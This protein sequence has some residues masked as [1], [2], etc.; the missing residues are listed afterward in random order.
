M[1]SSA[2]SKS[3][4]AEEK[5]TLQEL[6]DPLRWWA[7]LAVSLATFMTY[8]DLNIINI[9]IPAIQHSLHL[10]ESGL[11]WVV[12]SYLLTL[13]GLLLTGGRL[14]D[15]YGRRLLFIIGLI[16]FTLSSLSAGLAVNGTIL[17]TSRA[18]Q[19]VGAAVVTPPTLA[20]IT[21]T[22][23]DAKER[24]NA[25]GLWTVSAAI[26]LA[27][28]PVA[29]GL[30]SQHIH[31]GWIFLINVPVGVIA[32]AITVRTVRESRASDASRN[33]DVIGLVTSAIALFAVTYALIEGNDAGWSSPRIIAAFAAFA[34]AAVLFPTIENRV[35][36]PMVNLRL[37][38]IRY[39][40]GGLSSQVIWAFGS[41][42]I[43][44]FTAQY[45]QGV[46]GWSP[47]KSGLLFL[48]MAAALAVSAG[49]STTVAGWIGAY[50][51]VA[52]G[53]AMIAIGMVML[54][55]N[56][57]HASFGSLVPSLVVMGV[58]MGIMNAP[59]TNAVMENTPETQTGIA[60]ALLNDARD[61]AGLLG[62]AVVGA[63]LRTSQNSALRS[64]S[65]A[66]QAFVDGYHAGILVAAILCAVGVAISY[67]LL[68][69]G[70]NAAPN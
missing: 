50:R 31:W 62:I 36:N 52:L 61:V 42:A 67:A 45:L 60:S 22:F 57:E 56:G 44:F 39:F 19:G 17:I 64:G 55:L 51:T 24:T 58:G 38:R 41:I 63:V 53:L 47:L 25:I 65:S 1:S 27:I 12:S 49:A 4:Q 48:P 68:R 40:T 14:A 35:A 6:P 13:A 54:M 7:L 28:G 70:R 21:A 23:T 34:A 66:P 29:S 20:I 26:A 5:Q 10:T 37:F 32:L 43:Y 15:A 33:L 30:I 59:M 46:L 9:A 3:E 2:E 11:E 8:L 16:I 18:V 69:P